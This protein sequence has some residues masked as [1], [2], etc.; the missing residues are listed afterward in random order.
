MTPLW[1]AGDDAYPTT[2]VVITPELWTRAEL[3]AQ[4]IME[5][6]VSDALEHQPISAL[7][8]FLDEGSPGGGLAV[9]VVLARQALHRASDSRAVETW[10][11]TLPD[12]RLWPAFDAETTR[13]APAAELAGMLD[14]QEA[15]QR[16]YAFVQAVAAV[17]GYPDDATLSFLGVLGPFAGARASLVT[18]LLALSRLTRASD[19]IG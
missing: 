16:A 5:A 10:E 1:D 11:G 3:L 13:S 18:F 9:A 12:V 4:R 6:G 15:L 7:Q 17:S 19:E 2:S 8:K 14:V